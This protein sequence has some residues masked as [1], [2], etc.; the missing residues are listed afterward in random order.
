MVIGFEG[1]LEP[2]CMGFGEGYKHH[3]YDNSVNRKVRTIL[4]LMMLFGEG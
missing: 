4:H 3:T 1:G 2:S